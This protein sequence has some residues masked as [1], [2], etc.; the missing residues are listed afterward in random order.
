MGVLA[1]KCENCGAAGSRL[2][3]WNNR[4][5]CI[6]CRADLESAAREHPTREPAD[7]EK[8][9]LPVI[10]ESVHQQATTDAPAQ[11]DSNHEV[12]P[13]LAAAAH[14]AAADKPVRSI[15]I[16]KPKYKKLRLALALG[17]VISVAF[18]LWA[19]HYTYQ[20]MHS[21]AP[22]SDATSSSPATIP[23]ATLPAS[24]EKTPQTHSY[25]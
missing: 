11:D 8:V 24:T 1:G 9:P 16:T 10:E 19:F 4:R 6:Q 21:A 25:P 14:G 2:F 5:V 13:D 23:A 7:T 22:D 20:R 18:M 3:N 12:F 15:A 17:W